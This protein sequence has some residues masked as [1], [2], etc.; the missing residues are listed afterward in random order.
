MPKISNNTIK[1]FNKDINQSFN[2]E[3][4][5]N[6]GNLFYAELPKSLNDSWDHLAHSDKELFF[7]TTYYK[8]QRD[9]M[10]DKDAKRIVVADNEGECLNR[11]TK[12]I[13][14]LISEVIVKKEVII[15]FYNPKDNCQYGSM[16]Y[17]KEHPQIGIQ[18][19]LTY[20]VETSVGSEGN[21]VYN[22]YTTRVDGWDNEKTVIDR[23]EISVYGNNCTIIDDTPENRVFLE[24]IY[25][26]MEKLKEA[27]KEYTATP[28]TL[29]QLISSNQKLLG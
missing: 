17:N 3:I 25:A 18:F 7:T 24:N 1:I 14:S 16:K 21:K 8:S 4:H 2:I 28:E 20:A 22:V 6:Q 29:L 5:Y 26:Q 27:L 19:A 10:N 12:L 23:K 9:R 15:V 13:K 11:I